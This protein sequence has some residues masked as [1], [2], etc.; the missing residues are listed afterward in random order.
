MADYRI[1]HFLRFF[2]QYFG[3]EKIDKLR[4]TIYD[5]NTRLRNSYF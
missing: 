5:Y 1:G 2:V 3:V 4:K